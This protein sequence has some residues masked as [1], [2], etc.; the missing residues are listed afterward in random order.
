MKISSSFVLLFATLLTGASPFVVPHSSSNVGGA[1][2]VVGT[3]T[4]TTGRHRGRVSSSS[5]QSTDAGAAEAT[6]ADDVTTTTPPEYSSEG[7]PSHSPATKLPNRLY[8]WR[9]HDV[10][11]QVSG[12]E[13]A[14]HTLLLIHGLFV[15]SDHW[16]KML[17]G[18]HTHEDEA[19]GNNCSGGKKTYRIYA[20]DL[21]GS[22]WSS[23]PSRDDPIARAADGE[24]GRFLGCDSVCYR[25]QEQSTTMK[26]RPT[27]HRSPPVLENVPLGTAAG[28]NRLA[29]SLELRHPLGSPYNF[30][31]WAEQIADFVHDVVHPKVEEGSS[32]KVTLVSNSIGT[33]S[34]LQSI[35]DEPE[36]F[37]GCFVIN[38][39]FREL[40]MAEVPLSPLTMPLVRQIQSLLRTRGHG[41]FETL[42]TPDTV[43]EI[44]KEPYHVADAI[45][46]ELVDVLLSPLLTKG[47]DD[48]VFDT[49]SYSAG[50][51]PEQQLSS[52]DFPEDC[53]VW[54]VYGRDDPWTPPK[55]V[56]NLGRV[57]NGLRGGYGNGP[58]ERV[59]G[60]E[61]AGHC[62]HDEVP[63]R[64]N[65]LVLEFL[66]R[67]SGV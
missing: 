31:T 39:N 10:R 28:G 9:G 21:L 20:L 65:G 37:D 38:P 15:N 13:D 24:N 3:T 1:I 4:S 56:E 45:D 35:L 7:M 30:Y 17:T 54:V 22:G 42:A 46:K 67:L 25:E 59:V 52:P 60:L 19:K 2:A 55:R 58:V 51:L 43:T 27:K 53:P 16:R 63:E 34:A 32:T 5:L 12:P 26:G 23:K 8:K 44:L 36:L 62:P 64:V 29:T 61:G 18:L 40:H 66:D 14:D 57:C 33:M 49:L 48:V 11:Y 50:P 47:A 6:V 41:L